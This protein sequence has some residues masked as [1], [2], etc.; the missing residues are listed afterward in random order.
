M[1]RSTDWFCVRTNNWV[2][3]TYLPM[4][5]FSLCRWHTYEFRNKHMRWLDSWRA[6]CFMC[7]KSF[8]SYECMISIEWECDSMASCSSAIFVLEVSCTRSLYK[9][10][11]QVFYRC[12]TGI[13][14]V[15]IIVCEWICRASVYLN[16][17]YYRLDVIHRVAIADSHGVV[18]GHLQVAVKLLS[19][20]HLC[21][22]INVLS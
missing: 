20:Q 13:I 12:V 18:V 1:Q 2:A 11:V 10:L 22:H 19:S 16:N 17:V 14:V 4:G 21:F 8:V 6:T 9:F 15:S 5:S 3:M 7:Y